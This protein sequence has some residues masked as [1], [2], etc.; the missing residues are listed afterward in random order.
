MRRVCD[1]QKYAWRG[2]PSGDIIHFHLNKKATCPKICTNKKKIDQKVE[3]EQCLYFFF[4]IWSGYFC[5]KFSLQTKKNEFKDYIFRN[6]M[7][8][9]EVEKDL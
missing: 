3:T 9:I 6:I 1:G 7:M 5:Y 8:V 2:N 4:L